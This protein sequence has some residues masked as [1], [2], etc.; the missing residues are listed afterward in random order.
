MAWRAYGTDGPAPG[1]LAGRMGS[2]EFRLLGPFGAEH[3]GQLLALG[4]RRQRAILAVLTIHAGKVLSTDHI[5]EEIWAG[6]PPPSATRTVHAYVSRLRSALRVHEGGADELFRREPGYV[7]A[8][9]PMRIDAVRFEHLVEG[10][11]AAL[12][13]GY[14]A[15]ANE[16][17]RDALALW[18]GEALADF[19]YDSFAA[20]ESRRLDGRR[21]QALELRID[22]DLALGRHAQL[23]PEV[24]SLVSMYPLRERF[25][26][27]C[28]VALYRCGRQS[29]ALATYGRV[30]RMLAD[31]LGLEPGEELRLLER[32]ILEQSAELG[33][34][35]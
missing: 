6:N 34:T 27:Q 5:A 8:V 33:V 19:A 10:A 29:D 15:R 7:L 17:L 12:D 3:D 18:R 13:A 20:T 30:R 14:P 31:D 4:G 9:D 25:W 26:A 1:G 2:I 21:L 32:Q 22:T 24:E 23:V 11:V 35:R 28:M 16:D